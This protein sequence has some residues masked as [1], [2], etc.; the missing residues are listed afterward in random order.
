MTDAE[1]EIEAIKRW[2]A[3]GRVWVMNHYT[4]TKTYFVGTQEGVELE[5]I[6]WGLSWEDAFSDADKEDK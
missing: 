2:G 5:V 4:P 3:G 6:G 1:A